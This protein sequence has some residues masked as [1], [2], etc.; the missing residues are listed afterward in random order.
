VKRL[1]LGIVLAAAALLPAPAQAAYPGQNGRIAFSSD[2]GATAFD[3]AIWTMAPDGSDLRQLT[4]PAPPFFDRVPAWSPDGTHVAFTRGVGSASQ[5]W[6]V[7]A[8]GSSATPLTSAEGHNTM[9]SWS[10]DGTQIAFASSRDHGNWNIWVMN[11]DGTGQHA[12]TSVLGDEEFPAWSPA[13]DR[14][15]HDAQ[16]GGDYGV[17]TIRPD[18]A[19][20]RFVT[21][22]TGALDWSP[23]ATRIAFDGAT[24]DV[25]DVASGNRT[26]VLGGG[27]FYPAWSPDGTRIVYDHSVST[28]GHQDHDI[29][30]ANPDGSDQTPLLQGPAYEDQPDWQPVQNRPPD[31]S[32]VHATPSSLWPPNRRFV[33]VTFDGA[34]DPDGD[35][36]TVTVDGVTQDEPVGGSADARLGN[37][38]IRLRAE[39]DPR[40]DGRVYRIAFTAVDGR[41]GECSG[42]ATVEVRRH[43]NRPAVDSAPPSYDSLHR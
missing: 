23:D 19:D 5:V 3:F 1:A 29:W 10:P 8:D 34:T 37:E 6:V 11:S 21:S 15:A 40:G 38:R 28:P 20:L 25:V 22:G 24:V 2:R 35:E 30:T 36:V 12:V 7:G 9:P 13:G 26:T 14:I 41:G 16:Y 42:I 32:G 4:T 43:R 18:G 31:C 17:W 39:R 27:N 33:T